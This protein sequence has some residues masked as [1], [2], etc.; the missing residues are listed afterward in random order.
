MTSIVIAYHNEGQPFVEECVRQASSTWGMGEP[1]EIIVVDDFSDIPLT[2]SPLFLT[3]GVKLLRNEEKKGV[4]KVFDLGIAEAQ[5][6]NVIMLGCD[7]RFE[8]NGWAKTLLED[9]KQH[10]KALICTKC[11]TLRRNQLSME[12][13]RKLPSGY[14]CDL[15][16]IYE[17]DILRARWAMRQNKPIYR[18][19]VIMGACYAFRKDWYTYIEG[20]DMYEDKGAL[21]AFISIKNWFLGG[22]CLVDTTVETGHIYR[23]H[24]EHGRK[25]HNEIYNKLLIDHWFLE[26]RFF[27]KLP[28]SPSKRE[29]ERMFGENRESIEE[30]KEKYRRMSKIT[31]EEYLNKYLNVTTIHP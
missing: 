29:A 4:G 18:V 27:G 25:M 6:E 2:L 12:E 16:P 11:I 23:D 31:T 8:N 5:G 13:G 1:P 7:M 20:W 30:K 28:D 24:D 26:D 10:P 9:L 21:E 15:L 19:P 3:L 14:G 22:E 17:N